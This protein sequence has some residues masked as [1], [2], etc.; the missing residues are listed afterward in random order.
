MRRSFPFSDDSWLID[1]CNRISVEQELR[2]KH[3]K[4]QWHTVKDENGVSWIETEEG[5]KANLF[6]HVM[7]EE[8]KMRQEPLDIQFYEDSLKTRRI[9][10]II[11]Y[12]RGSKTIIDDLDYDTVWAKL[13]RAKIDLNEYKPDKFRFLDSLPKGWETLRFSRFTQILFDEEE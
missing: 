13:Q 12:A 5:S 9:E 2:K 10:L 7:E 3:D 6:V 11:E 1:K 4:N 8:Y